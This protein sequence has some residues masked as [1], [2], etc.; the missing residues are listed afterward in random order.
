MKANIATTINGKEAHWE[1]YGNEY[2]TL[3]GPGVV[4][5]SADCTTASYTENPDV[6][7]SLS[8]INND[9]KIVH[10]KEIKE[11][12][13]NTKLFYPRINNPV[14]TG[15]TVTMEGGPFK[16]NATP[17]MYLHAE[18]V[19]R[20]ARQQAERSFGEDRTV[21][22]SNAIDTM[23]SVSRDI[24]CG[25]GLPEREMLMPMEPRN[26]LLSHYVKRTEPWFSDE[27]AC[28]FADA[29]HRSKR[30]SLMHWAEVFQAMD[31]TVGSMR[32]SVRNLFRCGLCA[33]FDIENGITDYDARMALH[34][35]I[36]SRV[37]VGEI[38][39]DYIIWCDG[40]LKV[41]HA[42]E[43]RRIITNNF[44]SAHD[45]CSL[46]T[47]RELDDSSREVIVERICRYMA[48]NFWEYCAITDTTASK[49]IIS[50]DAVIKTNA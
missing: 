1:R 11:A 32:V 22:D 38:E 37:L 46:D 13:D 36:I 3:H 40:R 19:L 41:K 28:T 4:T 16:C 43:Y 26:L 44:N 35:E 25:S 17:A 9:C 8:I 47:L 15:R 50:G 10:F 30:T 39:M 33:L 48:H 12:A 21:V 42:I 24:R 6:K 34:L 31:S 14:V 2:V 23:V 5:L 20:G 49:L 45:H 29:I 18:N 7:F 27:A